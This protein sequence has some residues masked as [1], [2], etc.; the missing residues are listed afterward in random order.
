MNRRRLL[1][2]LV[3]LGSLSGCGSWL[4]PYL[5]GKD[6]RPAPNPLTPLVD[7]R[8]TAV[9]WSLETGSGRGRMAVNLRP[10]FDDGLLVAVG[11]RGEVV[12]A[13]AD[14]GNVIWRADTGFG[15]SAGAGIGGLT[16]V[17]AGNR[18]EVLALDRD[19]GSERW[20]GQ[21]SSE[22]LA[23][24]QLSGGFVVVRSADGRFTA[25]DELTGQQRWIYS[26]TVPPLSLRGYGSPLLAADFVFAGLDNGKLIGLGLADGIVRFERPLAIGSG[27]TEVDRLNDL[28][29]DLQLTERFLYAAAYQGDLVAFE[30]GTGQLAWRQA[31]NSNTGVAANERLVVTTDMTDQVRAFDATTGAVLW[32][33]SALQWRRLTAPVLTRNGVVVGDAEGYL[34]W[35]RLEDGAVI[36]RAPVDTAGF[37]GQLTAVGRFVVALGRN[38]RLAVLGVQ[39]P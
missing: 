22:V 37:A 39:A 2:S 35:L 29:G 25:F 33:Q 31:A 7:E 26:Q 38:G 12:A 14:S 3:A 30:V 16:V 32:T 1:V 6:N 8:P 17:V 4:S 21:V 24:P 15:L 18:G 5:D 23:A 27:R 13:A 19:N 34:H 28:D 9:L 11:H 36:A 20:R 10:A